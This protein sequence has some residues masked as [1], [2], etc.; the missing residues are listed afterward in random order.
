MHPFIEDRRPSREPVPVSRRLARGVWL[1]VVA[2]L[3]A[4]F[5]TILAFKVA[6]VASA[7]EAGH[8]PSDKRVVPLV[9]RTG[10]PAWQRATRWAVERWNRA[11]VGVR[12]TWTAAAGPCD[13]EA[14]GIEVC[15]ATQGDLARLDVPQLQGLAEPDIDR[16]GHFRRVRVLVCADCRLGAARRRVV[17]TH[18]LGHA[19]GLSHADGAGSLMHPAGG[20]D[21]PHRPD[22]EA[23]RSKHAH[24]DPERDCLAGD[25]VDVGSVCL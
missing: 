14:E 2:V 17:T 9:D 18:E 3:A 8:W 4:L 21:H 7:P 13:G 16:H 12:L 22:V 24:T 11:D 1:T 19:L 23:L 15:P 5:A 20:S 25:V 6:P 10:D